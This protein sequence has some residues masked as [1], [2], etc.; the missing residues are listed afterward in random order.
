[1]SMGMKMGIIVVAFMM[2]FS[3]VVVTKCIGWNNTEID[4][5]NSFT[6]QETVCKGFYDK[7]WKVLKSQAG[8][9][10]K[11]AKDFKGIYVGIMEGRHKSGGALFKMITES[12]PKF[13]SSMYKKLMVSIEA[14]REGFFRE[15]KKLV[16]FKLTHDNLR[17]KFPSKLVVGSAKPLVVNL[18]TSKKTKDVFASGEENDIDLFK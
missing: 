1:M 6:A 9:T 16:D 14:Q 3:A 11:Y 8:V 17:Q 2:L 18:I 12:N 7:M 13:D 5:R 15:Q 10:D 4:L